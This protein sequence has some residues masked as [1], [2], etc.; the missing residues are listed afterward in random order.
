M[1]GPIQESDQSL[2]PHQGEG[3]AARE[4]VCINTM[5]AITR[6]EFVGY[7]LTPLRKT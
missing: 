7:L 4:K 3:Q 6:G 2:P 1:F 5:L